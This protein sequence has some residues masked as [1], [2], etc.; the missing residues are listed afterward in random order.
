M[1]LEGKRGA[2]LDGAIIQDLTRVSPSTLGHMTDFGFMRG[3]RPNMCPLKF[4]GP[5]V[6]VKIPHLDSTAVHCV[7][8]IVKRGDVVV[9]DQS[10]DADRACWGGGV[11]FAAKVKG[12]VGAVVDGAI[13]DLAEIAELQLP[14]FHRSVSAL[15]TRILGLEGALNVPVAVGG[16]TVCPGDVVFADENGVAVLSAAE[17]K[18]LAPILAAKEHGE[19]EMKQKLSSGQSLADLSGARRLF[20]SKRSQKQG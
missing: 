16:V 4:A 7:L 3:L 19:L 11:S 9:V 20:E 5:A 6:T 10:G 12:V 2:D 14:V 1:F 13:T 15:T 17:A 18:R 8:D